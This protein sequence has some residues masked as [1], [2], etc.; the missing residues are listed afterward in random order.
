MKGNLAQAEGAFDFIQCPSNKCRKA[1]KSWNDLVASERKP[2]VERYAVG[3][4]SLICNL[5]ILG[6]RN[7]QTGHSVIDD[8]PSVENVFSAS[9]IFNANSGNVSQFCIGNEELVF[10]PNV[11]QV[12]TPEGLAIPSSVRLYKVLDTFDDLFRGFLFQSAIDGRFKSVGRLENGKFGV[13]GS[14]A[15]SQQLNF[16]HGVIEGSSEIM[17]CV[18]ENEVKPR[19]QNFGRSYLEQI[20]AGCHI[21]L[22]ERNVIWRVDE[23]ANCSVEVVDML[24]GPLNL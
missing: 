11:E 17:N 16:I 10:I 20:V 21:T 22:Q 19:G 1:M 6:P 3:S 2:L 23:L 5:N 24:F 15:N 12:K 13:S 8:A 7:G 14:L 9:I 18:P 4:V